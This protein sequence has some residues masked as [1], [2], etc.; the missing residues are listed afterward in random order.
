M[1][2]KTGGGGVK[3]SIGFVLIGLFLMVVLA[4]FV[5]IGFWGYHTFQWN[6]ELKRGLCYGPHYD[7][8]QIWFPRVMWG[9]I[10][11]LV[12]SFVL[13]GPGIHLI[14]DDTERG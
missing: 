2:I 8:N 6:M 7:Q 1:E 10:I 14:T 12:A 13:I 9:Y 3:K 5:I 4:W 11:S